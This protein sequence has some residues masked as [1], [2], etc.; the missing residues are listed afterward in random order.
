[1]MLRVGAGSHARKRVDEVG[2]GEERITLY[3][4]LRW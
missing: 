3:Q 2:E 4:D 1:M